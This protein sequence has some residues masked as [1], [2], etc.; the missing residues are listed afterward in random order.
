MIGTE[1]IPVFPFVPSLSPSG[2][3]TYERDCLFVLCAFFFLLS[4]EYGGLH[5]SPPSNISFFCR[6]CVF[7]FRGHPGVVFHPSF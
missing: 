4:R 2:R 3:L 7:F 1:L 5:P 6:E